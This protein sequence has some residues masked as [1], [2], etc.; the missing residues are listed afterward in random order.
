MGTFA[1][2]WRGE[3]PVTVDIRGRR[4][5]RHAVVV[6]RDGGVRLRRPAQGWR[7]VI[8][9]FA[10]GQIPGDG[11]DVVVHGGNQR[12]IRQVGE[13]RDHAKCATGVP[14]LIGRKGQ[15]GFAVG[16]CR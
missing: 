12:C 3:G 13:R 8:G 2:C 6:Q 7:G 15:Q 5:H 1:Q 11:A 4:A 10:V 9:G 16:L 14:G